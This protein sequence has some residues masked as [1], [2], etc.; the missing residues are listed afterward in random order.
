[1]A[2]KSV[3]VPSIGSLSFPFSAMIKGQWAA[4]IAGFVK[5]QGLDLK[6][7]IMY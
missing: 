7:D 1:M 2:E 4:E 5:Y 6:I 3:V